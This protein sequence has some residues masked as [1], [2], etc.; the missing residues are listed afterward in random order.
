MN[1]IECR[2][3]EKEYCRCDSRLISIAKTFSSE[4]ISPVNWHGDSF[5]AEVSTHLQ[6]CPKCL[7]LQKIKAGGAFPES[8]IVTKGQGL[9]DLRLVCTTLDGVP[10]NWP[11]GIVATLVEPNQLAQPPLEIG[12][13]TDPMGRKIMVRKE[14]ISIMEALGFLEK[15]A[16]IVLRTAVDYE[17]KKRFNT[18]IY[19]VKEAKKK[20]EAVGA[21]KR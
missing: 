1:S 10:Q 2:E 5:V 7:V 9:F 15:I 16:E 20:L 19:S 12:K 4:R 14:N 8:S 6:L 18:L 21:A 3:L 11:S 13:I 17:I